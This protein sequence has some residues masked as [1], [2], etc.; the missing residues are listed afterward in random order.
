MQLAQS[1]A[2]PPPPSYSGDPILYYGNTQVLTKQQA[3]SG[4]SNCIV[5]HLY[6]TIDLVGTA[7]HCCVLGQGSAHKRKPQGAVRKTTVRRALVLGQGSACAKGGWVG[8]GRGSHQRRVPTVSVSFPHRHD[9]AL[10]QLSGLTALQTVDEPR[11][12][13]KALVGGRCRRA[14]V[15]R[16]RAYGAG[17]GARRKGGG[18]AHPFTGG[19]IRRGGGGA[20]GWDPKV[21]VP[22]MTQ[23]DF[24]N[25]KFRCFP[26]W[27]LW[28]GGEGGGGYPPP[29]PA[30]H[31]PSDTSLGGWV[32]LSRGSRGSIDPPQTAVVCSPSCSSHEPAD[33]P[34]HGSPP[35]PVCLSCATPTQALDGSESLMAGNS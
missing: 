27:S 6:H 33:T 2:I 11:T 1:P 3:N 23:Q 21:C 26:R 14:C 28:S 20:G 4:I 5:A 17:R 25:G 22:K 15:C 16:P 19:S 34:S 9:W 30:V 32:P 29:P 8:L 13:T 18:V 31:G 10:P 24:P 12:P 35:P 7:E